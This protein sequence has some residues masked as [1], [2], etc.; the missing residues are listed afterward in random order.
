MTQIYCRKPSV[1][2]ML[3]LLEMGVEYIAWHL[4]PNDGKSIILSRQLVDLA[5]L[6]GASSTLLIHSLKLHEL[7]TIAR[8]VQPDYLLMSSDRNDDDMPQLAR[9]L[10]GH[11]KL[12]MSVPVAPSGANY[13]LGSV[14]I[15]RMYS[16]YAGALTVDT[17]LNTNT[18][19]F[20]CTGKVND[21]ETCRDI[22]NAVSCPV[23][24]AGGLSTENVAESIRVTGATIVDA[25]TSLELPDKS[26][27]IAEC[28]RFV[29]AVKNV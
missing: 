7:E 24:L 14:E 21:W 26:K 8:M 27:N 18:S 5:K 19:V 9:R 17:C 12:M 29:E 4:H 10:T 28:R 23:I 13:D 25:C 11:S 1:G 22:I 3:A 15:A 16:E 2:E 20:G 6:H